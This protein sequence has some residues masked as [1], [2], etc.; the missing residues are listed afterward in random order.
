MTGNAYIPELPGYEFIRPLDN[1]AFGQVYLAR[2]LSI[3]RLVAIKI[4]NS[5]AHGNAAA[6]ERFKREA[7]IIGNLNHAHI[8]TLHDF[9]RLGSHYAIVMEYLAGGTLTQ[10]LP[11]G[12]TE[13]EVL[14]ITR[15]LANAMHY[16]AAAQVIHRDIKPNN[17]LF[18]SH[19]VPKLADFG[20]AKTL[21]VG[22][23]ITQ[24]HESP[25]TFS[26]MSPEQLNGAA[27][28]IRSDLY[29]LG[30]VMYQMFTGQLPFNTTREKL[31]LTL[32]P[33]PL[34]YAR[35]QPMLDALLAADPRRRMATPAMLLKELERLD[36]PSAPAPST[37]RMDAFDDE[38][39][40]QESIYI[41]F[42]DAEAA[43]AD[44]DTD[45][46]TEP[47]Q[48][49]PARESATKK[50]WLAGITGALLTV[51]VVAWV[52]ARHPLPSPVP[53]MLS[54]EPSPSPAAA[55]GKPVSAPGSPV[56]VTMPLPDASQ[57]SVVGGAMAAGQTFRDVLAS[58]GAGPEMVV[59][60]GG[61]FKDRDARR[62]ETALTPFAISKYEIS[63]LEFTRFLEQTGRTRRYPTPDT[64]WVQDNKPQILVTIDDALAYAQWLSAETGFTYTV[65]TFYQ[66]GYAAQGDA[67]TRY[68][69]GGYWLP[70]QENSCADS[71][72]SAGA[73]DP[74]RP[75][76]STLA[77]WALIRPVG[78]YQPNPFGLYDMDGNVS[79]FTRTYPG[80]ARDFDID[81][82][83]TVPA[84][85]IRGANYAN[86]KSFQGIKFTERYPYGTSAESWIGIRM[87]REL[88]SG[89]G[90]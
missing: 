16:Y 87:V 83:E 38:D 42:D 41:S 68:W 65:P 35:Y 84:L 70:G 31:G 9:P 23:D 14:S 15:A 30:I 10:R 86:A 17:I 46:R 81:A 44:S 50:W 22:A 32:K 27:L 37:L 90:E 28:D 82:D 61:W 55:P 48:D 43:V 39:A 62:G 8:I 21:A 25:G 24:A 76:P 58:G 5:V 51:L 18:D 63:A 80:L 79:E 20:I 71:C 47:A 40:A 77:N 78:S 73:A 33:L 72:A 52:V 4:L 67:E 3:E 89:D 1:G 59:L 66:W 75:V 54:G 56:P 11:A 85:A 2:Q 6:V 45:S 12:L 64:R 60:A 57:A 34:R 69:W 7:R 88:G 13:M 53:A 29:S 74:L 49:F 36:A 26:Y 19:D